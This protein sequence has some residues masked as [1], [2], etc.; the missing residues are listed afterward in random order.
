MIL[1]LCELG[2]HRDMEVQMEKVRVTSG[3]LS[4]TKLPRSN[5]K[6]GKQSVTINNIALEEV[7]ECTYMR[8]KEPQET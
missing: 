6:T 7:E 8:N 3:K 5:H 2:R 4:E 1:L